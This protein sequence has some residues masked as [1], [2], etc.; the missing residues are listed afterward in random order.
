VGFLVDKIALVQIYSE[1]FGF[2]FQSFH[3]LLHAY[4]HPSSGAGTVCQIVAD[5]PS[6]L[7]VTP[8]LEEG[9]DFLNVPTDSTRS[10]WLAK[11]SVKIQCTLKPHLR[12]L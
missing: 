9:E 7:R 5:A 2:L 4:R 10:Y 11:A 1:Y 3:S 8:P 12:L 6:G